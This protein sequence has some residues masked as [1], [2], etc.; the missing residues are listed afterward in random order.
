MS[1][2]KYCKF[3]EIR[4]SALSLYAY[5]LGFAAN[6]YYFNHWDLL[7]TVI[8]II[9][10][11]ILD[12][13]ITA[14]NNVMDYRLAKDKTT[15]QKSV[16]VTESISLRQAFTCITVLL[17]IAAGLGLY[18]CWRTNCF[19]FFV[20]AFFFAL[21]LTYTSGPFPISRM[22]VGELICGWPQGMGIAFLL[23]YVNDNYRRM[24]TLS[25]K[26]FTNGQWH[27]A[28]NGSVNIILAFL[29]LC[30][31]SVFYNANVMLA[32]NLSD[33]TADRKNGRATLPVVFGRRKAQ[34]LYRFLGYVPFVL[35]IF[36]PFFKV[37]PWLTLATY[38]TFPKIRRNIET[39]L[40]KPNKATTFHLALQNYSL[41]VGVQA[42]TML[43]GAYLHF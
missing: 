19:L 23:T 18:L 37:T 10:E 43:A 15:K 36:M 5:A 35:L 14:I 2:K 3:V 7:N 13:M 31:P 27:F 21:V 12:N 22:P 1:I 24:I 9:A 29:L 17:L 28:L 11:I 20:G 6:F 25:F 34:T 4:T 8:F 41:F 42:I 38:A 30:L 40:A 33:R 39:F 26:Q 16:L 32:N